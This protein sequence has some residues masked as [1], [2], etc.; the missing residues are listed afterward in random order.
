MRWRRSFFPFCC[1]RDRRKQRDEHHARVSVRVFR[2]GRHTRHRTG[3]SADSLPSSSEGFEAASARTGEM[4]RDFR[5]AGTSVRLR[6]AGEALIPVCSGLALLCWMRRPSLAARSVS[7]IRKPRAFARAATSAL[8]RLHRARQ[9]L[10]FRQFPLSLGLPMGRGFGE[11]DGSR[12]TASGFLGAIAPAS[13]RVG[14]GLAAPQHPALV[15]GTQRPSIGARGR[16]WAGGRGVLIPGRGGSGKSSTSLACL[17]GGMDFISDDY[18]ALALD[19]EPRVYRLYSTA[20]L[21]PRDLDLYPELAARCRAVRQPGFDKVVLFL[22]DGYGEQFRE[23]LPLKL[24]LKP[25]ISGV[26]ETTLGPVE[27]ARNRTRARVGNSRA[28]AARRL[29]DGGISGA[30]LARFRGRRFTWEPIGPR[31]ARPPFGKLWA[32]G[33]PPARWRRASRRTTAVCL[34]NRPLSRGRSRRAERRLRGN[35]SARL[36][37]DGVYRDRKRPSM[38]PGRRGSR[39]PWTGPFLPI[40]RCG[41]QCRSLEPR[42]PGVFRGAAGCDRAGRPVSAGRSRCAGEGLRDRV[43]EPAWVRGRVVSSGPASC[44]RSSPLRGALIRKDA[45]RECGLFQADPFLQCSEHTDWLQRAEAKQLRGCQLDSVTLHV[46]RPSAI[47]PCLLSAKEALG[48]FKAELGRR[49]LNK[50]E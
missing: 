15:D 30:S 31:V 48:F 3:T 44:V 17:L 50:T 37:Q 45:F 43:R 38:R 25:G 19:P 11:R 10:G 29:Q 7:G 42:H 49:R 5:V 39:A 28:S 2:H 18:L 40:Q 46:A 32:P 13:A 14:A 22:E 41:H 23:S 34:R 6:F 12:D 33:P 24:V 35:R 47:Q 20:K 1:R 36:P 26:P 8:E 4:V 27:P 21:D 16:S 9:Y